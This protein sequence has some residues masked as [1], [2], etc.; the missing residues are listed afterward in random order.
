MGASTSSTQIDHLN[1]MII[2]KPGVGKSTLINSIFGK[3]TVKSGIGKPVTQNI[4]AFTSENKLLT[5]FDTPGIEIEPSQQKDLTNEIFQIIKKGAKTKDN[6]N[7]IHCI[8][9]CVNCES[10]RF[11]DR[12]EEIINRFAS[13]HRLGEIPVIIILTQCYDDDIRDAMIKMLKHQ[14][15]KIFQI[16]PI[17]AKDRTFKRGRNKFKIHSY[18]L[19]NLIEA[20][21]DSLP[22]NIRQTFQSLQKVS[23]KHKR[24]YAENI[25]FQCVDSVSVNPILFCDVALI[26][27]FENNIL[28]GITQLY[29]VKV[30]CNFENNFISI[31]FKCKKKLPDSITQFISD[32]NIVNGEVFSEGTIC[33]FIGAM[34]MTYI[35]IMEYIFKD[36]IDFN[37]MTNA[38]LEEIVLPIFQFNLVE[39]KNKKTKISDKK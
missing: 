26:S 7:I 30:P 6:N 20:T 33:I 8:W 14:K 12:E 1:I 35:Q 16:V 25:I 32:N 18:G 10:S 15:M 13:D 31:I 22:E 27:S 11:E 24:N 5:I 36:E 37:S 9:Y 2:G 29:D 21:N 23:L 3:N 34:G 28:K 19:N 17:I 4:A 38:E 39:E